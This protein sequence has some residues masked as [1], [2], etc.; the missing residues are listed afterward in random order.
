[1]NINDEKFFIIAQLNNVL[2]GNASKF[3]GDNKMLPDQKKNLLEFIE[4]L[5]ES[6]NEFERKL[7]ENEEFFEKR[8]DDDS[9]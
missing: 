1:M 9:R 6:I 4:K 3:I 2:R 5:K 8:K 7:T